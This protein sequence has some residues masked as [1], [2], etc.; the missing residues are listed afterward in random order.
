[1]D[2][3]SILPIAGAVGGSTSAA[4]APE[5]PAAQVPA[6]QIPAAQVPAAQA[7]AILAVQT[8][9]DA[10]SGLLV[11]SVV[12]PETGTVVTEVPPEALR[13]LAARTAEF[14]GK[15]LNMKL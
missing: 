5:A 10:M 4:P 2:I 8:Q 12:N 11:A 9:F 14:R 15:L 7:P 6:A 3:S 1:M 13:A